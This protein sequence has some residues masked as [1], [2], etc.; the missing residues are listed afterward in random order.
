MPEDIKLTL[1]PLHDF[2]RGSNVV[3]G[4]DLKFTYYTFYSYL[5]NV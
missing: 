5:V 4:L 3:F 1:Q 2:L